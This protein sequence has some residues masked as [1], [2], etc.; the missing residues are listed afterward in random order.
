[1][2]KIKF[3]NIVITLF[4]VNLQFAFGQDLD[5]NDNE[6]INTT[7][8]YLGITSGYILVSS[9]N[10]RYQFGDEYCPL[11]IPHVKGNGYQIGLNLKYPILKEWFPNPFLLFNLQ[12]ENHFLNSE[13]DYG[14]YTFLVPDSAGVSWHYETTTTSMSAEIN[15]AYLTASVLYSQKISN[16]LPISFFSG[17]SLSFLVKSNF[18]QIYSINSSKPNQ[19]LNPEPANRLGKHSKSIIVYDNAIR[20]TNKIIPELKFGISYE[21][22]I[23]ENFQLIPEIYYNWYLLNVVNNHNWR[24]SNFSAGITIFYKIN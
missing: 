21:K 10:A 9:T 19:E 22:N 11:N 16:S 18:K 4:V 17:L 2:M 1:M 5:V 23:Y 8:Y 13:E 15:I 20:N 24:M 14:N 6:V 12:V 7:N 3:K